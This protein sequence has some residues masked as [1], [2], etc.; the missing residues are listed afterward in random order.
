MTGH[1]V[2]W[3]PDRRHSSRKSTVTLSLSALVPLLL[4]S[5][6]LTLTFLLLAP[7]LYIE[8]A[9]KF[10]G[11]CVCTA[12]YSHQEQ[13]QKHYWMTLLAV[14]K[15]SD[16]KFLTLHYSRTSDRGHSRPSQ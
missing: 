6:L 13:F 2:S 15:V 8:T 1:P 16:L 5:S 3:L 14:K 10:H 12:T 7:S 4:F 11:V 9:N